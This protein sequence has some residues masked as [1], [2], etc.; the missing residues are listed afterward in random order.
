MNRDAWI[1][2]GQA[3]LLTQVTPDTIGKWH[4]RGWL[5]AEGRRRHL[6]VRSKRNGQ[7]EYRL[8]DILDAER[9]TRNNPN[10]RRG[11]RRA[12]AQVSAVPP[13][14]AGAGA[15]GLLV[16]RARSLASA[17]LEAA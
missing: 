9:D 10:S 7:L 1:T 2:R 11:S 8:G 5:D 4:A 16:G 15:P 3:A 17:D 14:L 12:P 13:A 6:T